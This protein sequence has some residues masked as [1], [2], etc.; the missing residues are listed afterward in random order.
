MG[1]E[2]KTYIK[3]IDAHREYLRKNYNVKSI[4]IFGSVARGEKK[5]ND[6]DILVGFTE[7]IG[8]FDFVGLQYYL[9]RILK[10]KVDLATK[11]ALKPL[12]KK[13]ILKETVYA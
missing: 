1:K 8:L 3:I 11:G 7:P 2:L 9:R 10:K 12:I 5:T 13:D 4:G 6:V